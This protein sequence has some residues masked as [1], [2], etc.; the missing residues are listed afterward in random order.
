MLK[1]GTQTNSLTNHLLSQ[2]S[3]EPAVGMGATLLHWTDRTA[4]TVIAYDG[5]VVTLQEDSAAR[6]DGR[7]MSDQQDYAFTANPDGVIHYYRKNRNGCWVRVVAN[8]TG[9]LVQADGAG[10]TIGRRDHYHDFSF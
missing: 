4:C 8:E 7:G 1:L 10:L 6:V 2:N 9:R 5:S 3:D